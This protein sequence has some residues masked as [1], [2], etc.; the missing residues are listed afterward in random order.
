[1]NWKVMAVGLLLS[2]PLLFVLAKGFSYDPR[3]LPEEL[4]GK[5]APTF[6]LKSLEGYEISLE[7]TKGGPVVINFW[8]TWCVPCVQEHKQLL[9]AAKAYKPKGVAFLGILYGD[10]A[11]KALQ[12]TSQHGSAYPTLIDDAQRTNIDYGVAGVPETYILDKE[13]III[14]KFSGPVLKADLDAVLKELL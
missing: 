4:T 5:M 2:V 12:F 7:D 9:D 3:A 1:M 14:K 10:T 13:G 8:A 6:T 11:E